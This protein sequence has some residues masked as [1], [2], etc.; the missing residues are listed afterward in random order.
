MGKDHVPK[1]A[2]LLGWPLLVG[3]IAAAS[4]ASVLIKLTTAPPLAVGAWRL[5]L[6]GLLLAPVAWHP[7]LEGWQPLPRRERWLVV[8]S[9]V[10]LAA[11]FA[12]WISSLAHTTVASSVI[13]V[14]SSPIMLAAASH[15]L[16]GERVS[17][18]TIVAIGL[19]LAGTAMVAYGDLGLTGE[20]MLGNVLALLGAAAVSIYMLLGRHLRRRLSTLAYVWPCYTI[21][22][23]VLCTACLTSGQALFGY[24]TRTYALLLALAIVPQILG[25]SAFNWAV[26]HVAPVYVS[27]AMLGEPIGATLLAWAILGERPGLMAIV[28][29]TLILMGIL[30]AS[31]S[32]TRSLRRS[33]E[34]SM[35]TP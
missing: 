16:L 17:G 29:G 24:S 19:A 25:H 2:S 5:L 8:A 12:A 28:G 21:A 18:T 9:G 35:G 32:I 13:L 20:A 34:R 3:G 1:T 4:T 14:S 33:P 27:V 10:A 30:A 11:H 31:P 23:L 22:G 26:R 15:W 6:A 7:T